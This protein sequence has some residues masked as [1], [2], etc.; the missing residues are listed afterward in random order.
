[1]TDSQAIFWLSMLIV[2]GWGP[3][4]FIVWSLSK[5]KTGEPPAKEF[6]TLARGGIQEL[7]KQWPS[8]K[9][10]QKWFLVAASFSCGAA[11]IGCAR[12]G[13]EFATWASVS[14]GGMSLHE[15]QVPPPVGSWWT[16]WAL[17]AGL[18]IMFFLWLQFKRS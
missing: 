11:V 9:S 8:L 4:I 18:S 6:V 13:T 14:L 17:Q 3:I 16:L 2:A 12:L 7:L 10:G 5:S 1:M 15:A